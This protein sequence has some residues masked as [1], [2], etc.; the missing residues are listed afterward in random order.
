MSDLVAIDTSVVIATITSE[1][2]RFSLVRWTQGTELVAPVSLA[3]EVGNAFSAM[4][5]RGRITLEASLVAL[6][7]YQRIPIRIL[8]LELEHAL[9]LSNE[10]GIYA[11]DA[12]VISCALKSRAPL[13]T[14]DSGQREAARR[15]GARILEVEE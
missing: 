12:Y 7:A 3:A 13:L 9:A 6:R 10:L 2:E 11:Y 5:R 4:F 14:L 15:A 8:P 1:S